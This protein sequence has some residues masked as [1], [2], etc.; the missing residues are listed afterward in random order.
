MNTHFPKIHKCSKSWAF[1]ITHIPTYRW[2]KTFV[3]SDSHTRHLFSNVRHVGQLFL[4]YNTQGI[5]LNDIHTDVP[6][7]ATLFHAR[8]QSSRET[9]PWHSK[10][11]IGH[12]L[13]YKGLVIRAKQHGTLEAK[14]CNQLSNTRRSQPS[15][16]IEHRLVFSKNR[17]ASYASTARH[18]NV[19]PDVY[20][21]RDWTVVRFSTHIYRMRDPKIVL[22]WFLR[23]PP[24][25][26]NQQNQH[27]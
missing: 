3:W 19:E 5:F 6:C 1:T 26:F 15:S 23:K 9:T 18:A 10:A 11:S 8:I 17:V 21:V 2:E 4:S 20:P 25:A 12:I 22:W 16:L 13:N 14:V 24:L 7:W 27:W